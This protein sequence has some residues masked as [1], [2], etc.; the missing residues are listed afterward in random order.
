[1]TKKMDWE[2]FK[3]GVFAL[4]GDG[5]VN[6][7]ILGGPHLRMGPMSRK[8]KRRV[9]KDWDGGGKAGKRKSCGWRNGRRKSKQV[10]FF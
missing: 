1:M 5:G 4:G 9:P 8:K 7:L 6:Q 10:F 3:R 2:K